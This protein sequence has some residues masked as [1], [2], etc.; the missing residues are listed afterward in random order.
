MN[1]SLPELNEARELICRMRA[2]CRQDTI[3]VD[4]NRREVER[5][6]QGYLDNGTTI[7]EIRAAE[8]SVYEAWFSRNPNHP[9]AAA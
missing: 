4:R 1:L 7:V 3:D 6:L 2:L 9:R 5:C 8:R